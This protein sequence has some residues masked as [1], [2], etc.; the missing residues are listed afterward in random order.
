MLKY[1][2]VIQFITPVLLPFSDL[3]VQFQHQVIELGLQV[4][5]EVE[6]SVNKGQDFH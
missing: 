3:V 5:T 4:N 2:Y 6:S 1:L